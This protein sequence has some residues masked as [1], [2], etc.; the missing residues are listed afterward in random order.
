MT[1]TLKPEEAQVTGCYSTLSL[2][3]ALRLRASGSLMVLNFNSAEKRT[4]GLLRAWILPEMTFKLLLSS[5][6]D[7][8]LAAAAHP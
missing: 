5:N 6:D 7:G 3:A 2:Q 8:K 4:R 1:I